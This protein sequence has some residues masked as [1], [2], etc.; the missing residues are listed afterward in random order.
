VVVAPSIPYI[1]VICAT[2]M[3]HS[4]LDLLRQLTEDEIAYFIAESLKVTKIE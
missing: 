3:D 1:N 4:T 2:T